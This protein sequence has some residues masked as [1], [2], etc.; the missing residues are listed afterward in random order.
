[1]KM[2]FKVVCKM[3]VCGCLILVQCTINFMEVPKYTSLMTNIYYTLYAFQNKSNELHLRETSG[4]E[5]Q[6]HSEVKGILC[7]SKL[8]ILQGTSNLSLNPTDIKC[9]YVLGCLSTNVPI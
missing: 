4:Q 9:L 3:N 8:P 7:E 5:S 2:D 6:G 1:M